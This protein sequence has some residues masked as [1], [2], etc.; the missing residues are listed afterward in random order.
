ML[1]P[2]I[3]AYA[4]NA[5]VLIS[6]V[7]AT[8]P[9]ASGKLIVLSAVGSTACSFVSFASAVVPSK[10]ILV[11]LLI[12]DANSSV[13]LFAAIPALIYQVVPKNVSV[14]VAGS[15]VC[16]PVLPAIPNVLLLEFDTQA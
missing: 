8:V 2:V 12:S 1:P 14:S 16:V 4:A 15:K 3:E 6:L 7:N 11:I 10:L 5:V 9:L 13:T